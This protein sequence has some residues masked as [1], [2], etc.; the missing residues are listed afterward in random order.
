METHNVL[1][2]IV[3]PLDG[4]LETES[5]NEH[6]ARAQQ[7]YLAQKMLSLNQMLNLLIRVDPN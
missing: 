6:V 1:L 5:R 2:I 7:F 3:S 4:K